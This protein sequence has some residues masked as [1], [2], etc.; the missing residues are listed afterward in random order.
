M[1]LVRGPVINARLSQYFDLT[2]KLAKTMVEHYTGA[3]TISYAGMAS[4]IE[5]ANT[6]E[7]LLAIARKRQ[8]N[9]HGFLVSTQVQ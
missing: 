5:K 2:F 8:I 7:Q 4:D 9:P 3:G 1:T 6:C